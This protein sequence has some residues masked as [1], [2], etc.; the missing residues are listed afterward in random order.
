MQSSKIKPIYRT[1]PQQHKCLCLFSMQKV[2]LFNPS[3]SVVQTASDV[4]VDIHRNLDIEKQVCWTQATE[5]T[6]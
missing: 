1:K 4:K 3:A 5:K 6:E 2:I